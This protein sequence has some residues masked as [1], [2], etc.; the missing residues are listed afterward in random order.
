M[1]GIFKEGSFWHYFTHYCEM[2]DSLFTMTVPQEEITEE[3]K[4]FEF[5][6]NSGE[7]GKLTAGLFSN[8]KRA[9]GV[10]DSLW[11][12]LPFLL[13][14]GLSLSVDDFNLRESKTGKELLKDTS[15]ECSNHWN[16]LWG[17]YLCID[18]YEN[19]LGME[20]DAIRILPANLKS[21]YWHDEYNVSFDEKS[22]PE[23]GVYMAL[24]Q[25]AQMNG[26]GKC[27]FMW[28]LFDQQ[29]PNNHTNSPDAFEDGVHIHGIAPVLNKTLV[30]HPTYYAWGLVSR[31]TG[32]EGTKTYEGINLSSEKVAMNVNVLPDGNYTITV[33]NYG[34]Q[35]QDVKLSFNTCFGRNFNRHRY[36]A[37]EIVPDERA[38]LP[39][40]DKI[41]EDV[42]DT[43]ID[44]LPP[45]SVAVYTTLED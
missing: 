41:F 4:K 8:M 25:V 37:S 23:H 24:G 16:V 3:W 38:I 15:F 36:I 7:G 35:T 32:G 33:V 2:R 14:N 1:F 40:T 6:F 20:K 19:W 45:M 18:A 43:I 21:E 10:K 39:A 28:T 22:D 26:G 17:R 5:T 13:A 44:T 9:D 11:N 31:Y 29:W 34:K 30:P 42:S 12:G 27:S